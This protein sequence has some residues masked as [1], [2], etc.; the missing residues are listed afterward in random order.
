[1]L[2][3]FK[4]KIKS[5]KNDIFIAISV[6]FLVVI[7]TG[8]LRLYQAQKAKTPV[9]Y[10]KGAFSASYKKAED[11]FVA[12]KNGKNYYPID[13]KASD[14]IKEEN[15]IFFAS[16]SDAQLAGYVLSARCR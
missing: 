15:K 7:G 6:T 4:E 11:A 16:A 10:E 9:R 3:D 14:V 8:A 2:P 13:C 12:S 1:M 5:R